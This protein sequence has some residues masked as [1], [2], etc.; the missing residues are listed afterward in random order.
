MPDPP[1][2]IRVL[3][4]L[5]LAAVLA[6]CGG[7]SLGSS[8]APL[9]E[10]EELGAQRYLADVA[11]AT[12]AV[13]DFAATLDRLPPAPTPE[14]VQAIAPELGESLA[15]VDALRQRLDAASLADARL[16]AQRERAAALLGDVGEEMRRLQGAA[17]RGQPRVAAD[18]ATALA[19]AVERLRAAG[20][21]PA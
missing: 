1:P 8:T 17:E 2:A 20:D 15:R 16:D 3:L 10:G 14:G 5:L 18:A 7:E 4:A 6:G 12:D 9:A 19:G 13:S 11:G 21:P